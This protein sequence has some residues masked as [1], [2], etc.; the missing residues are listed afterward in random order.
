[1][2]LLV[3]LI[4]KNEVDIYDI[5]ISLITKQYLE[6]IEWLKAMNTDFAGDFL[7]L[8][9]TLAQI[10]SRMLI[11]AHEGETDE[12]D[13]R[14][15]IVGPLVE[16]LQMKSAAEDL[17]SRNLLGNDVFTRS[18]TR[19]RFTPI[20]G[21]ELV[22]VGLFELIDAFKHIL[23]KA[24]PD[25]H[26]DVTKDTISVKDRISQLVDILE[27]KASLTFEELFTDGPRRS[28]VIVTFLALLEM[29]KVGL[30][31]VAQQ[32]QTG[33]IRIFYL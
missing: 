25:Q 29:V 10:K 15:E 32:V 8:A 20:P 33:I 2:D 30:I 28:D 23:E 27:R 4:K 21:E 6:Y 26:V 16:Y 18:P 24:D 19:E 11:P 7:V 12:E 3:H 22:K 14:A 1:M 13:P 9:A 17:A 5:P 31:Q